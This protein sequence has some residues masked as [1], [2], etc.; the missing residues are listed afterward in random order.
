MDGVAEACGLE[1]GGSEG[2]DAELGAEGEVECDVASWGWVEDAVVGDHA[3]VESHA[4]IVD[5]EGYVAQ[6]MVFASAC[7]CEV[8][9]A[10]E[11]VKVDVAGGFGLVVGVLVVGG[12]AEDGG[13]ELA[14]VGW[15]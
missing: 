6:G 8:G 15:E 14:Q 13:V 3:Y 7:G 9:Y 11:V 5:E 2:E 10:G 4:G 1:V 12:E